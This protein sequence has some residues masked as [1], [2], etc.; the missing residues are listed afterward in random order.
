MG[1]GEDTKLPFVVFVGLEDGLLKTMLLCPDGVDGC[2]V[3]TVLIHKPPC[4]DF[5]Q[6]PRLRLKTNMEDLSSSREDS[7]C[8]KIIWMGYGGH[9]KRKSEE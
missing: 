4:Q 1:G 3:P 6:Y 8:A 5:T 7:H 9:E 2:S